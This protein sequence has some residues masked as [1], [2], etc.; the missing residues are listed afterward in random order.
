MGASTVRGH[1]PALPARHRTNVR[2]EVG[3]KCNGSKRHWNTVLLDG[4]VP[5]DELVEMLRHSYQQVVAGLRRA[6]RERL[7]AVL[8]EDAPPLP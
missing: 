4:T 1:S 3:E 8:G 5:D 2:S 7:L 6:D